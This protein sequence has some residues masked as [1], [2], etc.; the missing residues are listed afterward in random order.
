MKSDYLAQQAVGCAQY[1]RLIEFVLGYGL[2][3]CTGK[4]QLAFGARDFDR[5]LLEAKLIVAV[6][7][8]RTVSTCLVVKI[9]GIAQ[10]SQQL[11]LEL[12][13]T[14]SDVVSR[15]QRGDCLGIDI[16]DLWLRI[17]AMQELAG[18]TAEHT[19]HR[20]R[21]AGAAAVCATK[22]FMRR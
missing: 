8:Q 4:N 7:L 6:C 11:D 19:A 13:Q 15:A 17:V 21:I 2:Q 5:T 16:V 9:D 22:R 10:V 12:A 3:G 18:R 20:I 14:R 1:V